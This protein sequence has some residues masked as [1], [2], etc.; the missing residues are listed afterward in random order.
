MMIP[1]RVTEEQGRA[2]HVSLTLVVPQS[3]APMAEVERMLA[4]LKDAGF[5]VPERP[6][7]G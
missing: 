2:V 6:T 4:V 3:T 5:R 1:A 7:W